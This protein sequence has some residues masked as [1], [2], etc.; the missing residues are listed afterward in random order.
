MTTKEQFGQLKELDIKA[1]SES[2]RAALDIQFEALAKEDPEGFENA[3][4][5]SARKTLDDAKIL[6]IKEQMIEISDII[7]MSYIAKNYFNKTKGWLSQR[8]N[9][10]EVNGKPVKFVPEELDTLNF[11]LQDIAAKIGAFRISC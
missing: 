9:G 8:V 5:E 7:S 11:A 3:V 2:K 6:R 4:K 10:H 1:K